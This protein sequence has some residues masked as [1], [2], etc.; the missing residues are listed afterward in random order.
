MNSRRF[1]PMALESETVR[2]NESECVCVGERGRGSGPMHTPPSLAPTRC[3][4]PTLH[5]QGYLAHKKPP[6]P[7]IL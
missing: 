5:V 1:R 4:I 3:K 2:D 6:P 7:S